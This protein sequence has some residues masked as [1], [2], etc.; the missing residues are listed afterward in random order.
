MW[1]D[2]LK[3]KQITTP[4]TDVNIKKI[5]KNKKEDE[6]CMK[7]ADFFVK[8]WNT[9]M[10]MS[11]FQWRKTKPAPFNDKITVQILMDHFVYDDYEFMRE[12]VKYKKLTT[13]EFCVYFRE[14]LERNAVEMN[15]L[16]G[17]IFERTLSHWEACEKI[18]FKGL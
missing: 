14:T 16:N 10:M 9:Q 15:D 18:D 1:T 13:D 6:C 3:I 8:L 11:E 5:P 4:F 7:A 2:I 17:V 12:P